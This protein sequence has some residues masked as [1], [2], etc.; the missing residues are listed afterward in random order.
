MAS[1]I[2]VGD[3][4]GA[5]PVPDGEVVS[6]LEAGGRAKLLEAVWG[7]TR[8]EASFLE[9]SVGGSPPAKGSYLGVQRSETQARG[10]V[11]RPAGTPEGEATVVACSL[12]LTVDFDAAVTLHYGWCD[13]IEIL[14][15]DGATLIVPAG[16]VH[17]DAPRHVWEEPDREL[18]E[19]VLESVDPVHGHYGSRH[20]DP[21]PHTDEGLL[22]LR[23]GDDVVVFGRLRDRMLS[24]EGGAYRT[25]ASSS[26]LVTITPPLIRRIPK[27]RAPW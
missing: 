18:V 23:A 9:Q 7:K 26:T 25:Q 17:L 19:E 15:A 10:R 21:F 20:L 3:D 22:R 16:R 27:R 5:P 24:A 11:V 2:S 12:E 14:L 8:P 6:L 4:E 13:E 1:R